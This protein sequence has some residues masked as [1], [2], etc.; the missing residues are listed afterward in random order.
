MKIAVTST[1]DSLESPVDP[2]FG[3]AASFL[4]IDTETGESS[5][6]SNEQNLNAAQGAGIQAA[7][8][9]EKLGVEWVL[10][11]HCG[12]KAFRVLQAAGVRVATGVEGT[13]A[14]AFGRFRAGDLKASESADVEGHWA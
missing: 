6:H 2:R 10:T 11:G 9:V 1:G 7:Q 3:R 8:T 14:E 5:A 13:V 4:V 12:P